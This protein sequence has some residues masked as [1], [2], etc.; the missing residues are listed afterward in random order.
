MIQKANLH[1]VIRTNLN[2]VKLNLTRF[3]WL[4]KFLQKT[5]TDLHTLKYSTNEQVT[6]LG[7]AKRGQ[8]TDGYFDIILLSSVFLIRSKTETQSAPGF[9]DRRCVPGSRNDK[10]DLTRKKSTNFTY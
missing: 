3:L 9:F 1:F 10:K 2:L 4:K 8:K 5:N 7:K 6:H